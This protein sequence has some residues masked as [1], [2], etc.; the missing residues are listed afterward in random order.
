MRFIDAHLRSAP[1]STLSSP[2]AGWKYAH[3]EQKGVPLRAE[4]G[5]RD[6]AAGTVSIVRR[7]TGAKVTM[8]VDADLP[9]RVLELLRVVQVCESVLSLC[10]R[11]RV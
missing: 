5:P 10:A 8:P 11:A 1:W 3:W 7:D 2:H 9:V 6:V 4:V